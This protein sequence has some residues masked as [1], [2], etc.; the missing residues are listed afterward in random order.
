MLEAAQWRNTALPLREVMRSAFRNQ[1]YIAV[2]IALSIGW[3]LG[4]VH[5]AL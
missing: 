5:R 4:R 1:P 2:T 3:L